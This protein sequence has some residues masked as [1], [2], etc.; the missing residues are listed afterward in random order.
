MS[1]S[2]LE[3]ED[4]VICDYDSM[5]Y[6]KNN[7]VVYGT[8]S[9]NTYKYHQTTAHARMIV[10]DDVAFIVDSDIYYHEYELEPL[11]EHAD[12]L[13]SEWLEPFKPDGVTTI[14]NQDRSHEAYIMTKRI[15]HNV[16]TNLENNIDLPNDIIGIIKN[17]DLSQS[18]LDYVCDPGNPEIWPF[19][20]QHLNGFTKRPLYRVVFREVE[21]NAGE[22]SDLPD[23]FNHHYYMEV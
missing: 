12:E 3:H 16:I 15:F 23:I 14:Y 21:D 20:V 6:V 8:I 7:N 1:R 19:K 2:P 4:R 11:T 9:R 18:G 5:F 22:W 13:S 17:M 10:Y